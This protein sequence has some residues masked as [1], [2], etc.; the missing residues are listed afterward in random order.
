MSHKKQ[1][2]IAILIGIAIIEGHTQD[3]LGK[4][5][6]V[7]IAL[8]NN[9][10]IR[11]ADN[12]IAIARNNADI[13]NSGYL[14]AFSASGNAT[15]SLSD[16]ETTLQTGEVRAVNGVNTTRFNGSVGLDYTIFDGMVRE[17]AFKMLKESYN[18]SELQARN[19][20]EA[21]LIN[22]FSVY[23]EVARLTE[24]ELNQ[25]R[26]LDVSRE[27]L[28]RATYSAEYG[29]NTQLDV[30]N[31]EVDYNNDSI[32]YLTIAQ[33]LSNEKRN[34]NLLLG[35]DVNIIFDVDTSLRY[36]E[37]I[38]FE[39][40]KEKADV[41]NVNI[42]QELASLRNAEYNVSMNKSASIPK[43]GLTA[44]YSGNLNNLGPTSFADKQTLIGPSV[45]AS[46]R[47]NIFDGGLTNTRKQ[48][49]KISLDNQKVSF[50][51]TQMSLQR[52]LGNAWTF[53]QTALF[54]LHAEKK[55]LE[56]N[57]RNFDRTVEQYALGQ[58]TN[59]VFRQAQI[60]LLNAELSFNQAK[61][62]AKVAELALY[63]ISGDLLI[64]DF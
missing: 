1:Y 13:K 36:S 58:I 26:T 61:Y 2:L 14:P 8:E 33:Q 51:Q 63:Q 34:L 49:A 11:T 50:E 56:T 48:N 45:G 30:L 19:V 32:N 27:R 12:N 37:T 39:T 18:L 3:I 4:Q 25:K 35:R 62:S 5:E 28:L 53:Y 60:N 55:N 59:I 43:I 24:N 23:Y 17:N 16:T 52:D 7:E 44:G 21:A 29:Q 57:Q 41:N 22:I 54:V 15:Y 47:W 38:N 64:A 31:A 20:I 6:A 40:L 9:F 42:L 46:L 10:N